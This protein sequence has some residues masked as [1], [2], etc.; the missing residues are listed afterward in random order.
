MKTSDK[1]FSLRGAGWSV[2]IN[3]V[4]CKKTIYT[5]KTVWPLIFHVGMR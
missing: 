2:E 5:K 4:L 3:I 1:S